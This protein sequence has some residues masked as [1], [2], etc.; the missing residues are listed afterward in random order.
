MTVLS[1]GLCSLA[2]FMMSRSKVFAPLI[3]TDFSA[4]HAHEILKTFEIRSFFC[5]KMAAFSCFAGLKVMPFHASMNSMT[6]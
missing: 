2:H 5:E 3:P 1:K 4:F 6:F